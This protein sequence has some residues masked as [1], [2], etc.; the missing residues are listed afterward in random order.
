MTEHPDTGVK[1]AGNQVPAFERCATAVVELHRRTSFARNV[2][3]D[4]LGDTQDEVAVLEW[5]AGH[6]DITLSEGH[7]G[8]V[9][10][11]HGV[12]DAPADEVQRSRTGRQPSPTGW[13]R[14][15]LR[16]C[17]EASTLVGSGSVE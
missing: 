16:G 3:W 14:S 9:L 7:P 12:G 15:R 11:G 2:G 8:A 6:N 10:L 1:F 4:V 17:P 13:A 5:N